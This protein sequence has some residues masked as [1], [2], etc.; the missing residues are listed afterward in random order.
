M[1]LVISIDDFSYLNKA[2][3]VGIY[4]CRN[5]S[6]VESI[7]SL[8]EIADIILHPSFFTY[9][10]YSKYFSNKN[11]RYVYPNDIPVDHKS[12]YLPLIVD[13]QINVGICLFDS[14]EYITYLKNRYKTYG[15]YKIN[16]YTVN[17]PFSVSL[18]CLVHLNKFGESYS[19][20]LTESLNSGLPI[21]YNNFG[22]YKERIRVREHYFK[23]FE[24]E[25]E[26]DNYDQLDSV[27]E[28]ML[29]YIIINNGKYCNRSRL[30]RVKYNIFY[31]YLFNHN[32]IIDYNRLHERILPYAM[33]LPQ[34]HE[35][36][37]NDINFYKGYHDMINLKLLKESLTVDPYETPCN[38]LCGSSNI[39]SYNLE[40]NESIIDKQIRIAENFGIAG[41][42]LYYFWFSIN[43]VTNQHMIMKKV[44]DRFFEKDYDRF[45][46]FFCWSNENW[47]KNAAFGMCAD[48][49]INIYDSKNFKE[50]SDDLMIYFRHNNYLKIDNK[51]V[52]SVHLPWH[53]DSQVEQFYCDL[54]NKCLENGFDG[55]YL[56]CNSMDKRY[57]NWINYQFHPNYK[58]FD[59]D[60]GKN[61]IDY[62]VYSKAKINQMIPTDIQAIFFDFDNSARLFKTD[63]AMRTRMFNNTEE[64]MLCFLK[65][66]LEP[67]KKIERKEIQK[68]FLVNAWNEWGEKMSIEPSHENGTY[69]LDLLLKNFAEFLLAQK[70]ELKNLFTQIYDQDI[71]AW[72]QNE[73]KSGEGSTL[74]QTEFLR[75]KLEKLLVNLRAQSILDAPCGDFNW[76]KSV[77]LPPNCQYIGYDIVASVIHRNREKYETQKRKFFEVNIC[78][79]KIPKVDVILCRDCLVHLSFDNISKVIKSFCQSG[80]TYLLTTTYPNRKENRNEIYVGSPT[81]GLYGWQALNLESDPF[82][83]PKPLL[84]INEQCSEEKGNYN[85]K[86]LG[87]W[88]LS[89]LQKSIIN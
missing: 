12:H 42:V 20:S 33:Y 87:L 73:S 28:K 86:C 55:I 52:F 5:I 67:Y 78:E 59:G 38:Y 74:K 72:G 45:R 26:S 8:F 36:R 25:C 56:L 22:A 46:V 11:F 77:R 66:L 29:D 10:E 58:R 16:Y 4:L 34:F 3:P 76:M 19:Y 61:M 64:S 24:N 89:D 21:I 62:D 75:P 18:H 70:S 54:N 51:P 50:N 84:Y 69:Y 43:S 32:L 14:G 63:L 23:V 71:W 57:D 60:R 31:D 9:D 17:E 49:I 35:L 41:F 47:T 15:D 39:E 13:N 81:S 37:E 82:N 85:D 30:S 68:I 88:K 83:F 6:I 65:A 7:R 80:S 48:T 2:D 1:K 27:F 40:T 53:F 79:D 44:I